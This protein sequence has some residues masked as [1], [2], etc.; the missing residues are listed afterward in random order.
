MP[1]APAPAQRARSLEVIGVGPSLRR[2]PH[3]LAPWGMLIKPLVYPRGQ[4]APPLRASETGQGP[5]VQRATR[6]TCTRCS[7]RVSAERPTTLW[8]S[9]WPASLQEL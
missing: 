1:A 5:P 3:L 7:I 4:V 9:P 6:C 2:A 8:T